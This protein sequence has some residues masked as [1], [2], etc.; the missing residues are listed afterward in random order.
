[1]EP[2]LEPLE[3]ERYSRHLLLPEVGMAGQLKLKA[4]SVLIVGAGGLGSPSALYLAAAGVGR[5]GLVD[6]DRVDRSNLH[7]QILFDH[8]DVGTLK[9]DRA[10]ERIHS[11]NPHVDVR[12]YEGRI[13]DLLE[14]FDDYDVVLDGTDTFA[15][16][17]AINDAAV[18][19]GKP[20][21]HASISQFEGQISVFGAPEGPCYRCLFP[22]PPPPHLVPSC[23][24]GGVLGVLPGLLGTM[25]AAEAIKWVLGLGEPLVGRLLLVDALAMRFRE[26][27]IPKDPACPVCG[28]DAAA[29][30]AT[31]SPV[32][33]CERTVP[34]ISVDD[35][36]TLMSEAGSVNLLD[37]RR[38][39]EHERANLGGRL[40]PLHELAGRLDELEALREA[41]APLVVYCQ[42][43]V[44]SGQA[45]ELLRAAGFRQAVNL[46]GGMEAWSKHR[47][48]VSR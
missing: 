40:I 23:A 30:P 4:A 1:M 10:H 27:R 25:Q 43:G 38:S 33:V 42:T 20:V 12:A 2:Q 22:S 14:L 31:P 44:R 41:T 21:V 9:V 26:L 11:L 19:Y 16:R 46:R 32:P 34:G 6:F 39:D 48:P 18:R 8:D 36:N 5:I 45:V 29:R 3:I 17:Y 28:N 35:L 24:E 37:V 15:T 7:R 47:P 13:G